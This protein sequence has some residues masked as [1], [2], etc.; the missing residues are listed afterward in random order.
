[1]TEGMIRKEYILIVGA[2]G[3]IG[4]CLARHM[5]DRGFGVI[6]IDNKKLPSNKSD[7]FDLFISENISAESTLCKTLAEIKASNLNVVGISNCLYWNATSWASQS[8]DNKAQVF[9]QNIAGLLTINFLL[10]NYAE[11]LILRDSFM[12]VVLL[13]SIHAI[14]APKFE[15]Y[16]SSDMTTPVEY[17]IA[18]H[19]LIGLVRYEAKRNFGSKIRIN[20]VSFGGIRDGQPSTFV[21]NYNDSCSRIG[22]LDPAHVVPA[23]GFLLS[24]ESQAITGQ[25]II[26]DDGWSL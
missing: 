5:R 20:C 19:G 18:K 21:S 12:S 15:H 13:G 11:S 14:A 2:L 1:M 17:T 23:I 3:R 22:L 8:T 6:G 10:C 25:N 16:Q 24:H 9:E 4:Y 26:V 7:V